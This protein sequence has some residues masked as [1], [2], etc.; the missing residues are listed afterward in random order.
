MST[1]LSGSSTQSTGTSWMRSPA[2]WARTSSSV[3]KNQP[4][5]RTNGSSSAATSARIAL[6]P[7]C[8]SENR[9]ANAPRSSRL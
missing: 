5:S 4:V 3:S 7:H 8:A 1:R 2:R 9:A 6:N